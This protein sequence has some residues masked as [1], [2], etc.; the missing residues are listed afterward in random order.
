VLTK[1][2]VW[3]IDFIMGYD[4][5][6]A[7]LKRLRN[8]SITLA[9]TYFEVMTISSATLQEVLEEFHYEEQIMLK[10]ANRLAAQTNIL[11]VAAFVKRCGGVEEAIRV[12]NDDDDGGINDLSQVIKPLL[13]KEDTMFKLAVGAVKGGKDNDKRKEQ[14]QDEEDEEYAALALQSLNGTRE[15]KSGIAEPSRKWTNFMLNNIST[16][17]DVSRSRLSS[18]ESFPS[19][20]RRKSS[21][22]VDGEEEDET[23]SSSNN[24]VPSIKTKK[25][26]A[27]PSL[28]VSIAETS[29]SRSRNAEL[30][31]GQASSHVNESLNELKASNRRLE[32]LIRVLAKAQNIDLDGLLDASVGRGS[33][34]GGNGNR[35]PSLRDKKT[36]PPSSPLPKFHPTTTTAA[37]SS[38]S[39]KKVSSIKEESESVGDPKTLPTSTT[40]KLANSTDASSSSSSNTNMNSDFANFEF[41]SPP[42]TPESIHRSRTNSLGSTI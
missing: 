2:S 20:L 14:E 34:G 26:T 40:D 33:S 28:S 17:D 19:L 24:N 11:R 23:V 29:L 32:L 12:Y 22:F 30:A 38:S 8:T 41:S 39:V 25:K 3:G 13:E 1:G 5:R 31:S 27:P 15:N 9:L 35:S 16:T 42:P 37:S 7:H 6:Y 36:T 10:Y 21:E 18:K 4:E